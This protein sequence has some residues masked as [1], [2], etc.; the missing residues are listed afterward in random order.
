MYLMYLDAQCNHLKGDFPPAAPIGVSDATV[1]CFKINEVVSSPVSDVLNQQQQVS[2]TFE[3][4]L[5]GC[6]PEDGGDMMVINLGDGIYDTLTIQQGA[7]GT[8]NDESRIPKVTNLNNKLKSF[9]FR[10]FTVLINAK[11]VY[12]SV[13]IQMRYRNYSYVKDRCMYLI[14]CISRQH[15]EYICSI[16]SYI[17]QYR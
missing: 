6:V 12:D 3:P 13:C 9:T 10:Q 16:Q 7:G 1:N 2:F 17:R 8:P 11:Q 15:S 5:T 14:E 4:Y